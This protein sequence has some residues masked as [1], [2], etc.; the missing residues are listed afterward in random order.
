MP[1][2]LHS[3]AG[4]DSVIYHWPEASLAFISR[5]TSDWCAEVITMIGVDK[6][7][8]GDKWWK[9]TIQITTEENH[10][11]SKVAFE[12]RKHDLM[13]SVWHR[14]S[15][16]PRVRQNSE[17][18]LPLEVVFH[19]GPSTGPWETPI[20][21]LDLSFSSNNKDKGKSISNANNIQYEIKF[22]T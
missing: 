12:Q 20:L 8:Q 15:S 21:F 22:V 16:S 13:R 4:K 10:V 3:T 9:F 1:P 19:R 11:C 2:T 7:D 14:S 17:L 5:A 18:I 6:S